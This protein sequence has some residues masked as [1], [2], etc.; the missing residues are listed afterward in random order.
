[1]K[2]LLI[3][4]LMTSIVY[5]D[6]WYQ[7]DDFSTGLQSATS[8]SKIDQSALSK[9]ENFE[10]EG[11]TLRLRKGYSVVAS[12]IDTT[13]AGARPSPVRGVRGLYEWYNEVTGKRQLLA[14]IHDEVW[15]LP[16]DSTRWHRVGT[17]TGNITIVI[18][19]SIG[20][21]TG[22]SWLHNVLPEDGQYWRLYIDEDVTVSFN[23]RKILSDYTMWLDGSA[24]ATYTNKKYVLTPIFDTTANIDFTSWFQTLFI[25]DGSHITR[26]WKTDEFR[27]SYYI[28]DSATISS[29]DVYACPSVG[30]FYTR[31]GFSTKLTGAPYGITMNGTLH[32]IPEYGEYHY[33]IMV[34]D[35]AAG[36]YR[37]VPIVNY[38]DADCDMVDAPRW[39]QC[40]VFADSLAHKALNIGTKI[41]ITPPVSEGWAFSVDTIYWGEV[42]SVY[43]HADSSISNYMRTVMMY[44]L[45]VI[46]EDSIETIHDLST[47]AYVVKI[48]SGSRATDNWWSAGVASC[49]LDYDSTTSSIRP[50][51]SYLYGILGLRVLIPANDFSGTGNTAIPESGSDYIVLRLNYYPSAKQTMVHE[52]RLWFAGT[53]LYPNNVY[54]SD[55]NDPNAVSPANFEI[56]GGNDNDEIMS[57]TKNA[58]FR[59]FYK[60]NHIYA[61]SG[62]MNTAGGWSVQPLSKDYGLWSGSFLVSNK[63]LDYGLNKLGLFSFNT[64]SVNDEFSFPIRPFFTDSINRA[65]FNLVSGV[66][67]DN[68]IM[69]SYPSGSNTKNTATLVMDETGAWTT[70]TLVGGSYLV[71]RAPGSLDSLYFGSVDSASVYVVSDTSL[72]AGIEIIGSCRSALLD[73]GSPTVNKQITDVYVH[74]RFNKACSLKVTIY[75]N[76]FTTIGWTDS[77]MVSATAGTVWEKFI[78]SVAPTEFCTKFAVGIET[79][80]ADTCV[81]DGIGL[82]YATKEEAG[83]R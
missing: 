79:I 1:M 35:T 6:D 5:A 42:D 29:K 51:T 22:S 11:G 78:R 48:I 17:S 24:A 49:Y 66:V 71:R 3:I 63:G 21:G 2:Y 50:D 54:W 10:I 39:S 27:N 12:R 83:N 20:Y 77:S 38:V 62:D 43:S 61:L 28:L 32:E 81:I 72:D 57:V 15:C 16:E 80:N 14:V 67:R 23:V 41:Y 8:P 46:N 73:F 44:D 75:E 68:D 76:D 19:D 60:R 9:C 13:L 69:F 47:S 40:A 56:I 65:K 59:I 36:H 37:R 53:N 25:S 70:S 52:G 74:G 34:M 31:L 30:P 58:S 4:L 55:V 45:D 18:A 26:Q 82:K 33:S 64:S 7:I